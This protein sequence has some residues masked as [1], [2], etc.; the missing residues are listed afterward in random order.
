MLHLYLFISCVSSWSFHAALNV[1]VF[2]VLMVMLSLP[3]I[4]DDAPVAYLTPPSWCT[5]EGAVL[6]DPGGNRSGMVWLLVF[7]RWCV[8]DKVQP[9]GAHPSPGR[10]FDL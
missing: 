1:L 7:I 9:D 6:V 4:F 2:H 10:T 5:V 3:Q 8:T